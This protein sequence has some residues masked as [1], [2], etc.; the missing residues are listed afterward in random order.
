MIE[1]KRPDS[2]EL[3]LTG[4]WGTFGHSPNER[5]QTDAN[6][7]H[8][9]EGQIRDSGSELGGPCAGSVTA[10]GPTFLTHTAFLTHTGENEQN[11]KRHT[12]QGDCRLMLI[13]V[14]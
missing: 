2:A 3:G 8:G 12:R 13:K 14:I 10:A 11:Y 5:P 7:L 9:T 6:S 1:L 4:L